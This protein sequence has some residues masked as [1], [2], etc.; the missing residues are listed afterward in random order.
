MD[1]TLSLAQG[2]HNAP[3][4]YGDTTV[5]KAEKITD[6]QSGL[7]AAGREFGYGFYDGI[8]GLVTQPLAGAQKEGAAGFIK[9]AAKGFGGLILKPGAGIWGLPGYTAKG[10]YRELAKHFGSSVQNYIIA[11][12]TAQGYDEW[13]ESDPA[14]R[15]EIVNAWK[16]STLETRRSGKKYGSDKKHEIEEHIVTRTKSN[17]VELMSGFKN[18]RHLTWDERKALAERRQ[19]LK[20]EEKELKRQE[21][22]IRQED[23]KASMS[24]THSQSSFG[25]HSSFNLR[26]ASTVPDTSASP[27]YGQGRSKID[28]HDTKDTPDEFEDAIQKSV[29]TTSRGDPEED[30]MIERA[31]RASVKELRNSQAPSGEHD[32]EAYQRAVKASIEEAK[33][34]R[35]E[36]SSQQPGVVSQGADDHDAELHRALT[37]SLKEHQTGQESKAPTSQLTP[38]EDSDANTDDDEDFKKDP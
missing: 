25:R 28:M 11:A 26:H 23:R 18:T 16:S 17:S 1:F 24:K 6:L 31:L 33:K 27:S 15:A 4:L 32:D 9:G 8:T 10:V 19:Q 29:T 7:K 3:K 30:A 35:A 36:K 22:K 14:K 12:R 5:R 38:W 13:K 20:K 2:F 34:S 21:E 37:D